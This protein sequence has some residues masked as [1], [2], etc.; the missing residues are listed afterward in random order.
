MSMS[1]SAEKGFDATGRCLCGV[2]TFAAEGVRPGINSCHCT[3]CIR[4][5]GSPTMAVHV[6][7][8]AFG[9]NQ[10]IARFDSSAWAER[11][12]CKRCGTHLFYRLKE[13]DSYML[14]MGSFDDQSAF[15]L[16][17]EI[18]IDEKPPAYDFAGDHPRLTAA[19]FMASI[20]AD[21]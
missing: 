4:W 6:G 17:G 18:Y 2:V 8:V 1:D 15:K 5:V 10:H 16:V 21:N 19:E 3:T 11:G 13:S 7:K 20:Q 14:S 12:F 9:G